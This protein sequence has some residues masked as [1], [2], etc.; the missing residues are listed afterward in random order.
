MENNSF[1]QDFDETENHSNTM[2]SDVKPMAFHFS[3][4]DSQSIID[5]PGTA[6]QKLSSSLVVTAASMAKITLP[7]KT[8]SNSSTLMQQSSSTPLQQSVS[9]AQHLLNRTTTTS[10][11]NFLIKTNKTNG[12]QAYVAIP[13]PQNSQSGTED[14]QVMPLNLNS[15]RSKDHISSTN[16]GNLMQPRTKSDVEAKSNSIIMQKL[17][18]VQGE[19][20]V[21]INACCVVLMY[22]H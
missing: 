15:I 6:S 9:M 22:L 21:V 8:I 14:C 10:G 11:A 12:Q 17:N 20:H 19:P 18:N 1:S 7:Q 5:L 2:D 13:I 3:D 16:G 4:Y